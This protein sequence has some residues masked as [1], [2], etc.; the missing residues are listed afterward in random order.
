MVRWNKDNES[1]G[2]NLPGTGFIWD[3]N[4]DTVFGSFTTVR[5]ERLLNEVRGQFSRYTDSRAAKCEGV[6]VVRAAYATSGCYDQGT[7]GVLPEDTYDIAN[8]V[9]MWLGQH[10]IKTGGSF[11]YDVTEQLFAPLQNGVYRFAGSPSVAPNPFQYDQSFA[12]VPEARLMFHTTSSGSRTC[13]TIRPRPTRTTSIRGSA[14]RG[15]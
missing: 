11:T 2:L 5:S 7:W 6:T 10:T 13:P 3:N 12:L 9:T 15:M 4:V 1:G 8:T 14:S